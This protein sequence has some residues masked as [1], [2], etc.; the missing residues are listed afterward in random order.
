MKYILAMVLAFPVMGHP[1]SAKKDFCTLGYTLE[2]KMHQDLYEQYMNKAKWYTFKNDYWAK[3]A[4]D[5]VE[6]IKKLES[7]CKEVKEC[8][9]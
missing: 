7:V 1:E 4:K 8:D 2:L 6:V 5:E 9:C 3:R